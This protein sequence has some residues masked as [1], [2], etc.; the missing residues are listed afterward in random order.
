MC[1]NQSGEDNFIRWAFF[2]TVSNALNN[3]HILRIWFAYLIQVP[4][5]QRQKSL[6][7]REPSQIERAI[8]IFDGAKG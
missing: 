4:H 7:E 2:S 6:P 8:A 1:F 5:Y 3:P